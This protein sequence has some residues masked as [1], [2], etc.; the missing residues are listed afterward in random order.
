MK[1]ADGYLS[2]PSDLERRVIAYLEANPHKD[3]ITWAF[4]VVKGK[5]IV[6]FVF[7]APSGREIMYLELNGFVPLEDASIPVEF[8]LPYE[9]KP[10]R[11]EA[12]TGYIYERLSYLLEC[13][14]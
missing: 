10:Q 5:W 14:F 4:E 2:N 6:D 11:F 12:T 7:Y 1:L 9:L 13:P 3:G 8:L